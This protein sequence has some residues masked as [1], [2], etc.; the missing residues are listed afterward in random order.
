[1][2]NKPEINIV[3]ND[4]TVNYKLE[5]LTDIGKLEVDNNMSSLERKV[6]Y[7]KEIKNPYLFRVDDTVVRVKYDAE[8]QTFAEAIAR[9]IAES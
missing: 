9:G 7:L 8:G 4:Q 3:M 6:E 1:M 5:N 2:R